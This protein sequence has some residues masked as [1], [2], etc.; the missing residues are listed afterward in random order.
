MDTEVR[1]KLAYVRAAMRCA[2]NTPG[3]VISAGQ[4]AYAVHRRACPSY[5]GRFAD[6]AANAMR[7]HKRFVGAGAEWGIYC[8]RVAPKGGRHA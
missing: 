7:S 5:L 1:T 6:C 8:Y 3:G 4:V 2:R